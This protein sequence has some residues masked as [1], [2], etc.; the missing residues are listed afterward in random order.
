MKRI[1]CIVMAFAAVLSLASCRQNPAPKINVEDEIA[2]L[3]NAEGN[4][5]VNQDE[6]YESIVN[7]LLYQVQKTDCRGS[8]IVATDDDVVFA[9]GSRLDTTDG[10]E[11]DPYS[12]YEIGSVT[13]SF[14]A[15][16]AMKLMEDKKLSMETTLGELYPEYSDCPNF[17]KVGKITMEDLMHMRSGLADYT[18]DPAAFFGADFMASLKCETYE[19]IMKNADDET[20]L[21]SLFTS[22]PIAEPDAVTAYCNTNYHALALIIEK[23]TEKSYK[24][25]VEELIFKPC[26]MT[27]S[28]AEAAD[29]L[30]AA[31]HPEN[32]D[33]WYGEH[34][35]N[36]LSFFPEFSRGAGDIH[37]NTADLLKYHRALFGGALLS[38]SS[39]DTLL[40]PVENYACGWQIKNGVVF[41]G[42]DTPGFC[43]KNYVLERGGGRLYI[44]VLANSGEN[45]GDTL[46]TG[47][48]S[49]SGLDDV[50][51]GGK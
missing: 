9:S 39:M 18:N 15:V 27:S 42:G 14:T 50:F 28:T 20:F 31:M 7:F 51:A 17:D 32:W 48:R 3:E 1:R 43:A 49:L 47:I 30:T 4:I 19:E 16:C 13:K 24:E 11:V 21:R 33:A 5:Y 29:G 36:T 46:L 35:G 26:G 8:M 44:I 45:C 37:S 6:K 25:N 12:V 10:G 40:E 23:L 2:A 34:F 41:H 38:E 22:E